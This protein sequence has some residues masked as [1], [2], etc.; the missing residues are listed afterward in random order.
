MRKGEI[1]WK[2]QFLLF[3]Q[4]FLQLYIL[5][6]SKCLVIPNFNDLEKEAFWKHCG[7]RRKC[8][9][10]AFSP[11]PIKFSTLPKANLS[12][13][14]HLSFHLQMHWIWTSPKFYYLVYSW[15]F[16][17]YSVYLSFLQSKFAQQLH[18]KHVQ[19][20]KTLSTQRN[21]LQSLRDQ[22]QLDPSKK[23]LDQ[24]DSTVH[25]NLLRKIMEAEVE[26][27]IFTKKQNFRPVQI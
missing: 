16:K 5:S 11:F 13:W 19:L 6:V 22:L 18:F 23:Q 24:R 12:F 4:C 14:S 3:S 10:P 1:A 17:L 20:K 7:K 15:C 25:K 26:I 9:L 21:A 8:W 27:K 2:K